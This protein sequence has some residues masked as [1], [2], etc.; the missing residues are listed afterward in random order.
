M[1]TFPFSKLPLDPPTAAAAPGPPPAP[2]PRPIIAAALC[3]QSLEELQTL[4]PYLS[5]QGQEALH[6]ALC[7]H[8]RMQNGAEQQ[9]IR[10]AL[11]RAEAP[12]NGS[13]LQALCQM[14]TFMRHPA[15]QRLRQLSAM[16]GR[17]NALLSLRKDPA[18]LLSMLDPRFSMLAGLIK[19]APGLGPK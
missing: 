10:A 9:R 15:G 19:N 2:D 1:R 3:S 4:A 7:A 5:V 12:K 18:A 13:V 11:F 16:Q 6:K 8:H 17:I 14:P